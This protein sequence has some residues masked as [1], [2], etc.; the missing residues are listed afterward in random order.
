[1]S[2]YDSQSKGSDIIS[3]E[4]LTETYE[5]QKYGHGRSKII[6][7]STMAIVSVISSCCL[8]R[9]IMTSKDRLTTTYHRLMLGMSVGDILFLFSLP[10]A[11]F[12]LHA[13]ECKCK[14]GNMHC[15]RFFCDNG[16]ALDL[17]LQLFIEYLLLDLD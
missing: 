12:E 14:S 7:R 6:I 8:I 2:N 4:T 5:E 15:R 1:M 13:V 17:V 10:L 16:H 3:I 9:M 11:T